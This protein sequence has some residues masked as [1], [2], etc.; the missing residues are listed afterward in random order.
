MKNIPLIFIIAIFVGLAGCRKE[1]TLE[2][3]RWVAVG[4]EFDSLTLRLENQF[5]DYAPFDSL[6]E[7]I[8][9]LE[10]IAKNTGEYK[11]VEMSRVAYWKA[12]YHWRLE[13]TDSALKF[14]DE[15]LRLCDTVR[16]KYDMHRLNAI[17][18]VV[19]D[20]IDG[21]TLYRILEGIINYSHK[22]KDIGFEA[23]ASINMG[24]LM[25]E[26]GEY[27]R[28]LEY[29]S[30]ADSLNLKLGFS[31]LPIKDKVNI[32]RVLGQKGDK[33]TEIDMLK[34]IM[35][36][37]AV[38][39]DE[40][41]ENVIPRNLFE[42]TKDIRYL[43]EAYW[44]IRENERF[45]HL[46]GL[47][48]ALL[49][50]EKYKMQQYDS[51]LHYASA[52]ADDLEYVK[53]S[54]HQS[55]VWLSISLA[56]TIVEKHDSAYVCRIRYEHCINEKM[57]QAKAAEVLRLNAAKEMERREA[58][59]ATETLRRNVVIGFAVLLMVSSG[60]IS[61]LLVNRRRIRHR[62]D[63]IAAELDL[64]KSR[65]KIVAT[66][67]SMEE[68]DKVLESMKEELSDMRKSGEIR[69]TQARRLETTIKSHLV[70][71]E[72]TE[73]FREMFDVVHPKFV[74][75]LRKLCPK[76]A[77]SYIRLACYILMDLDNYRIARL[78][79]IKGESVRQA[80]WRLRQR[81]SVPEGQ[82]LEEF[83]R[84]LNKQDMM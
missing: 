40:Y 47:Y 61:L 81:L 55:L 35:G 46:R 53:D 77:D 8:A 37:P 75:K 28:A 48:S 20:T 83:L 59:Y 72:S 45:R 42:A 36:H 23:I 60:V 58:E 15:G 22:V 74:D 25:S 10:E 11:N 16:H 54:G 34:S 33:G 24:N 26:I 17:K 7:S 2:P 78:M 63:A 29:F 69:E 1:N 30:I 38:E 56:W 6:A 66:T 64:E 52:A 27:D 67:L 80:K 18:Y 57:K 82:S 44:G 68:K 65:R 32:S 39:G 76:L 12:R 14:A 9:R 21:G 62:M 5:N 73:A 51:V 43:Y 3:F 49:A 4:E 71:N 41:V 13:H 19:D 50:N 79:M 70:E 84:D 31:K